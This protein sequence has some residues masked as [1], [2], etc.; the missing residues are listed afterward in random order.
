M[1][2]KKSQP[3]EQPASIPAREQAIAT[4]VSKDQAAALKHLAEIEKKTMSDVLR[5]AIEGHL[6][7]RSSDVNSDFDKFRDHRLEELENKIER[8]GDGLRSLLVKSIRVNGQTL[9]F[10]TLPLLKGGL[11]T[12]PMPQ[13]FFDEHWERS[14]LMA[15]DLL[16]PRKK[17]TI[18]ETKSEP[19]AST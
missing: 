17:G 18:K 8:L 14:H 5:D 6:R 9:Y 11:P 13:K 16:T 4:R 7:D 19:G 10:A 1:P 12:K 3:V 15:N 2:K